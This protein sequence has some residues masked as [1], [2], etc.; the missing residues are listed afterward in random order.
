MLVE[1]GFV[2]AVASDGSEFTFTPSL[3]RIAAL[4]DPREI[5]ALFADLHGP[6]AQ[7]AAAEVLAGLCDQDDP[8]PLIGEVLP[9]G[10]PDAPQSLQW[11]PGAMSDAEMVIIARHLMRHGIVGTARPEQEGSGSFCDRFDAAEYV[12]AARVHLG[13]SSADAEALSMTEFQQML[14]MKYPRAQAAKIPSAKE[15]DAAMAA[16][17]EFIAKLKERGRG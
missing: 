9:G 14:A 10:T 15:Y 3:G 11:V 6:R 5:V 2:R 17:D 1:C 8:A 12:S 7:R 16:A 13:L 4:G